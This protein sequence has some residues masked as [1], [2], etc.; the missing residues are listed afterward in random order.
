MELKDSSKKFHSIEIKKFFIKKSIEP[1]VAV[2]IADE[3]HRLV[4]TKY[5]QAMEEVLD[6]KH[7]IDSKEVKTFDAYTRRN[8][9]MSE[10]TGI[11]NYSMCCRPLEQDYFESWIDVK[12][13]STAL[14]RVAPNTTMSGYGAFSDA[15]AANKQ[16]CD[17][18]LTFER[19]AKFDVSSLE[20]VQIREVIIED[21]NH[22]TPAAMFEGSLDEWSEKLKNGT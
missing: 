20:A 21:I 16:L 10:R 14:K 5:T 18:L 6:S 4:E 11:P 22:A 17:D 15:E 13:S 7:L 9:H 3:I 19:Y 1:P 8:K 2:S 12:N